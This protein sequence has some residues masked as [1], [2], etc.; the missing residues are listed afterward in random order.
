MNRN[1]FIFL[2][3]MTTSSTKKDNHGPNSRIE[4][5]ASHKEVFDNFSPHCFQ[6]WFHDVINKNFLPRIGLGFHV[7]VV[8]GGDHSSLYIDELL[9]VVD[10][11]RIH[12]LYIHELLH[13]YYIPIYAFRAIDCFPLILF[14]K[15]FITFLFLFFSHLL[16]SHDCFSSR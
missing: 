12:W 15:S 2:L 8:E 16:L 1:L 7:E 5:L 3:S 6:R 10:E 13:Y 11:G 14:F 9:E 4:I